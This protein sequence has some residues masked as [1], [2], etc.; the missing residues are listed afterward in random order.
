M[1]NLF[2]TSAPIAFPGA[3]AARGGLPGLWPSYLRQQPRHVDQSVSQLARQA[4]V[5]EKDGHP[6][7]RAQ[8]ECVLV[9]RPSVFELQAVFQL[10]DQ[11]LEI[12]PSLTS[13]SALVSVRF[14]RSRGSQRPSRSCP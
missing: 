14:L 5:D 11:L 1:S 12:H 6:A 3:L 9:S 13:L 4:R 2:F 10:D 8:R 7:D